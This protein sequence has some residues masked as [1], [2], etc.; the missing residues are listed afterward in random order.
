MLGWR[1]FG[2][3]CL[4]HAITRTSFTSLCRRIKSIQQRLDTL[5]VVITIWG[6]LYLVVAEQTS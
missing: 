2:Q 6:A 4:L 3:S 5:E 1:F